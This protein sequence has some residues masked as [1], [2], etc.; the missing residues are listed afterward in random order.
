M[1]APGPPKAIGKGTFSS[2]F[3]AMLATERYVA[4]RSLNSLATGLARSGAGVPAPTLTGALAQAGT[5][6]LPLAEAIAARNRGSWHLHADETSWQVLAPRDGDGPV[7]WWLW[8]FIGPDTTAFVMDATR[9]AAVLAR[10]AGID[11][12]TGQLA[13]G[14]GEG[15]RTLVISSDF[16]AVYESAGRKA[17]GIVNLYCWAHYAELLVMPMPGFPGAGGGG[18]RGV[19][20]GIIRGFRGR[21]GAGRVGGSGLGWRRVAWSVRVLFP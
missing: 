14:D 9:S 21:P 5:L 4:G 19:G 11:E 12:E 1:T 20:V 6:L 16:Y 2:G 7:K 15:P 8:C 18:G 17:D 10:H 13:P 3:L